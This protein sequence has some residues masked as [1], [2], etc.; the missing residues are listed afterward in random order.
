V[1]IGKLPVV[2]LKPHTS[3][4]IIT[5]PLVPVMVRSLT[6]PTV[7]C[8]PPVE[9]EV[10]LLPFI[11]AVIVEVNELPLLFLLQPVSEKIVVITTQNAIDFFIKNNLQ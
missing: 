11:V 7:P 3:R 5:L 2:L 1:A 8:I 10:K 9:L 4:V 6:P